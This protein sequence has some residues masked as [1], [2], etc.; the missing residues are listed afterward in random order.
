M[1]NISVQSLVALALLVVMSNGMWMREGSEA[2]TTSNS[3]QIPDLVLMPVPVLAPFPF[4]DFYATQPPTPVPTPAPAR[5]PIRKPYKCED[6]HDTYGCRRALLLFGF[7]CVGFGG[8][9]CIPAQGA[10]YSDFTSPVLCNRARLI[11][12]G[13]I[14]WTGVSC[15]R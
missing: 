12:L 4:F 9:W 6:I 10:K 1:A 5:G 3:S 14:G 11:G 15:I 2:N 13:C 7:D 8:Q